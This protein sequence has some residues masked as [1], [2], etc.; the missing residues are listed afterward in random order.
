MTAVAV[1]GVVAVSGSHARTPWTLAAWT[2]AVGVSGTTLTAYTV[3]PS[4]TFT[5]G[6]LGIFSVKFDWAAVSGA[7]S[8]TMHY[9]SGGAQTLTATATSATITTAISAGTAWVLANHDFGSA[10]WTSAASPTRTY[11][12]AVWSLCS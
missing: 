9:G 1:V 12:V 2:D 6:A 10:T 7:T 5:C 4:P 3:P 11:T 8:Y